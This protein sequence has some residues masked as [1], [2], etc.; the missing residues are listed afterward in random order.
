MISMVH[1][2]DAAHRSQGSRTLLPSKEIGRWTSYLMLR[3]AADQLL[4]GS[5]EMSEPRTISPAREAD[6]LCAVV[7]D[8]SKE[9]VTSALRHAVHLYLELRSDEPPIADTREMPQLLMPFLGAA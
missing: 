8:H 9:G 2:G 4:R 3:L 5:C 7:A 1:V 6:K